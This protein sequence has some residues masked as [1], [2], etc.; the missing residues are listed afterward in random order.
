MVALALLPAGQAGAAAPV[1]GQFV[2]KLHTEGLG[3]APSSREWVRW[4]AF[5]GRAGCRASSLRRAARTIYG[6]REFRRLP[7]DGADRLAA[8]HRGV[9]N[10]DLDRRPARRRAWPAALRAVLGG[11]SF[12]RMVPRICD[13]RS[14][15]YGFDDA[16]GVWAPRVRGPG[17]RGSE[18]QLQAALDR[19]ARRG[20]GTVWLAQRATI[21]VGD[22][23][24]REQLRIPPGVT[25]ATVGRPG[26][27]AYLRMAR[28]VRVGDSCVGGE[29]CGQPVVA[30]DGGAAL[31][32]VWVDG[33]GGDRRLHGSAVQVEGGAGGRVVA[34]RL[35]GAALRGGNV[36][37][38]HGSANRLGLECR[39]VRVS[40]NLVTGYTTSHRGERWADGITVACED[41]TV[42]RNAIV[43]ASDVGIA[44]FGNPG[45]VQRSTIRSNLVLAAGSSAFAGIA[46][47]PHGVCADACAD[48]SPRDFRGARITGN[49]LLTGPRTAFGLGIALGIRALFDAPPDGFGV[50]ATGN[51]T[52]AGSARVSVGV[53]V[54]GM[55]DARVERNAGRWVLVGA[56]T[57]PQAPLAASVSAGLASFAGPPPPFADVRIARCWQDR[58]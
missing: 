56:N 33:R 2:A 34:T 1:P 6:G 5:F 19:A 44:L 31:R 11:P 27:R 36:I 58:P 53:A 3:R 41:A 20:G 16:R 21:R 29:H 48:E 38:V 50:A 22:G 7:Y 30:L 52:G 24:V 51:D 55:H 10:R 37:G 46:A 32:S 39:G 45:T 28:L 42:E 49:E 13:R 18:E 25:L 9:L 17:F 35:T 4:V 23:G 57:C 40:G 8:L 15:A 54:S 12:A 47:D 43:D 26:P 14:D